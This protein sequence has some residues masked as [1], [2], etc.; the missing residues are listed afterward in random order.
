MDAAALTHAT[1]DTLKLTKESI[2]HLSLFRQSERERYRY[3]WRREKLI[4]TAF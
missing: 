4:G 1:L 3:T 2:K